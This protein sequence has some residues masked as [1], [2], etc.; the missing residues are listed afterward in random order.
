MWERVFGRQRPR[1]R[2][3]RL[4]A[5]AEKPLSWCALGTD[6]ALCGPST[7]AY[8]QPGESCQSARTALIRSE[9]RGRGLLFGAGEVVKSRWAGCAST[10]ASQFAGAGTVVGQAGCLGVLGGRKRVHGA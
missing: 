8:V 1:Q 6:C 9:F 7:R 2:Q 3:R 10:N 5:D 4:G